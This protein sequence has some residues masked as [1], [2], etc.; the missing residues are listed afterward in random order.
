MYKRS[1]NAHLRQI[2]MSEKVWRF[3]WPKS[4]RCRLSSVW[5]RVRFLLSWYIFFRLFF[6]SVFSPLISNSF[7]RT[8]R[9]TTEHIF[10]TLAPPLS[11]KHLWAHWRGLAL[12]FNCN[13]SKNHEERNSHNVINIL[14]EEMKEKRR[15][16][17]FC[18]LWFISF[19]FM[20]LR[21]KAD[22]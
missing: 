13:V 9:V 2:F 10:I 18:I 22:A 4:V 21:Y 8:L 1:A 5:F 20:I 6:P 17:L 11:Y 7:R 14:R 15:K 3:S 12:T 19:R 16:L